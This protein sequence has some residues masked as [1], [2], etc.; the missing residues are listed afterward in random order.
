[1]YPQNFT[2]STQWLDE[3]RGW[4]STQG[5][6]S[7]VAQVTTDANQMGGFFVRKLAGA[8]TVGVQLH[9]MWPLLVTTS[10]VVSYSNRHYRTFL[11]LGLC[12][13][14]AVL[15]FLYSSRR[16]LQAH[17][18]WELP[19]WACGV[20]VVEA[21]V[22]LYYAATYNNNNTASTTNSAV[23]LH[24]KTP[25]SLPSNIVARTVV[26]VGAWPVAMCLRDV[27]APGRILSLTLRDDV[28]LEWTNA[29]YH[30]P[31]MGTLEWDDHAA[32]A[33]LYAGDKFISQLCAVQLLCVFLYTLVGS[34]GGVRYGADG[35]GPR[36]AAGLYWQAAT[37]AHVCIFLVLR[38]FA[39]AAVSASWNVQWHIMAWGYETFVVGLFAFF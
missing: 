17:G 38:V 5:G 27:F 9:K 4:K 2:K 13:D 31:P 11:W 1:M 14:V 18:A 36:V 20:L 6:F 34:C 25:N 29:F 39:S 16:V 21:L 8:A 37:L 12:V 33:H 22:W 10:G 26:L 30:S 35:S 3:A 19:Q 23:A 24:G 7:A 32:D 28:Y 15:A